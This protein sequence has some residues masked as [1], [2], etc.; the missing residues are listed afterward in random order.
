[1]PKSLHWPAAETPEQAGIPL[2][3]D[4]PAELTELIRRDVGPSPSFLG[5]LWTYSPP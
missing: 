4:A 2:L 5:L 1:M 3:E